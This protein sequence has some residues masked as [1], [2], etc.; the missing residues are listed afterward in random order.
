MAVYPIAPPPPV[1]DNILRSI[2]DSMVVRELL[3]AYGE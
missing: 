1:I 2:C 3:F